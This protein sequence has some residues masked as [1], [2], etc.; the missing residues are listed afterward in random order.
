MPVVGF[1]RG[2]MFEIMK[3]S[4]QKLVSV[5]ARRRQVYQ[6]RKAAKDAPVVERM[7]ELS[8]QY[9]R[10]GYRRIRIFPRRLP[11][12][13][14][15]SIPAVAGRRPAVATQA[16]EVSLLLGRGRKR[17]AGRTRYGPTISC[18]TA[19]PMVSSSSV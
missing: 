9:P 2:G 12:E 4:P 5:P 6:G 1:L 15:P 3:E 17:R 8:A 11:H 7:R 16:P 19:V 18:S 13:P 10:Y 14:W